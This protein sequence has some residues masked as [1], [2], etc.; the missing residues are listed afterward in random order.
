MRVQL[1]DKRTEPLEGLRTVSDF[2]IMIVE[3]SF[4]L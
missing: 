2:S 1:G 3:L 4:G